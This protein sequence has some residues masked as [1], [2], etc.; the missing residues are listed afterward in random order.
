MHDFDSEMSFEPSHMYEVDTQ[1]K[2]DFLP[3]N[4]GPEEQR[5]L[6]ELKERHELAPERNTVEYAKLNYK[7]IIEYLNET[8]NEREI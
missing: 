3:T 5:Y 8:I 6:E 1:Q 2:S 7:Y 4:V